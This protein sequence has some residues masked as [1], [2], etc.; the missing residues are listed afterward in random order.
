MS[1]DMSPSFIC[2]T[3]MKKRKLNSRYTHKNC[4]VL[5]LT[6]AMRQQTDQNKE[7][8]LFSQFEIEVYFYAFPVRQFP[9]RM[10]LVASKSDSSVSHHFVV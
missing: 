1:A 3:N 5:D 6:M 2:S 8:Y 7:S 9:R 10:A 4:S